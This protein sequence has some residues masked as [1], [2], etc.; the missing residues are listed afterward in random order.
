MLSEE[1][2]KGNRTPRGGGSPFPAPSRSIFPVLWAGSTTLRVAFEQNLRADI[3]A[4]LPQ[5]AIGS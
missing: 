3:V 2:R 4:N 1:V 5:A